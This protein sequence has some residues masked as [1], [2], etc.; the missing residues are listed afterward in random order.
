MK[1]ATENSQIR[2]RSN[3][4]IIYLFIPFVNYLFFF[5]QTR[6][7][8]I[9]IKNY[10]QFNKK[11]PSVVRTIVIALKFSLYGTIGSW[12]LYFL[13][14]LLGYNPFGNVAS[15]YLGLIGDMVSGALPLEMSARYFGEVRTLLEGA[16]VA[17]D[18]ML[19]VAAYLMVSYSIFGL[20]G[21]LLAVYNV[22]SDLKRNLMEY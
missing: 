13:I 15:Y 22:R 17:P 9:S 18:S 12:I 5:F 7:A 20:L 10:Y 19:A 11:L 1:L 3:S 16:T 6:G 2:R 14:L 21:S 8:Y 4:S